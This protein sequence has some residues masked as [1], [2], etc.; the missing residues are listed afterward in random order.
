MLQSDAASAQKQLICKALVAARSVLS[1]SAFSGAFVQAF[2]GKTAAHNLS[3]AIE[4][5]DYIVI[6]QK[7]SSAQPYAFYLVGHAPTLPA[8]AT[9]AFSRLLQ[10]L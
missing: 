2:A 10:R 8:L 9:N 4:A 6:A 1:R 5:F 7:F 3:H